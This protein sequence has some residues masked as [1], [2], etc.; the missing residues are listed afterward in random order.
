MH[1]ENENQMLNIVKI[2]NAQHLTVYRKEIMGLAILWVFML[3]SGKIGNPVYDAVRSFGWV[4]VDVFFFLSAIGLCYSLKKNTC[5]IEFYKRRASRI[6][7]T[8]WI[9]L[10]GVHLC[11]LICNRFLSDLPFHA[12]HTIPQILCWYTGLGF[13]ISDFVPNAECYYYEWYVPSL[14]VFYLFAPLLYKQRTKTLLIALFFSIII[15]QILSNT[16]T[17]YSLHFFYQRVPI[18]I[19][20]FLCYRMI[21]SEWE[22]SSLVILIC[23]LI[24]LILYF[25]N[26]PFNLGIV[27]THIYQLIMPL[28]CILIV[29]VIKGLKLNK[30]FAFY[31]G[32]TLELY[33]IHL[34]KRPLYVVGLVIHNQLFAILVTLIICTCVAWLFQKCIKK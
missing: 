12:P 14:I 21:E 31:G 4:G 3:H 8:W 30:F 34:Y 32:I 10:L 27:S 11:G 23:A 20:G 25:C 26:S 7:P 1:I 24:G 9:I 15:S 28:F 17:L 19:S 2:V 29:W 16:H 22:K 6:L 13:W 33:L 18:F 5:I